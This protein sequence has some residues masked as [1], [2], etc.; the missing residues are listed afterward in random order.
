MADSH[1]G[2]HRAQLVDML[3]SRL[4][5]TCTIHTSKQLASYSRNTDS[6]YI[7]RFTDGSIANSDV[8]IGADG[9]RSAVRRSMFQDLIEQGR[10]PPGLLSPESLH[11][12]L[13]P[14]WSGI[15]VYR[16]LIQPQKLREISP[17]HLLLSSKIVMNVRSFPFIERLLNIIN[18]TW[19]SSLLERERY[20]LQVSRCMNLCDKLLYSISLPMQSP[21]EPS[22]I[23]S[24]STPILTEKGK[25]L[26][27]NG[28]MIHPRKRF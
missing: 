21:M 9:I 7:M 17:D 12:A 20:A 14:Q 23:S 26:W 11:K 13:E 19:I 18:F 15:T 27:V 2:L 16:S 24:H 1:I 4:P 5:P 3:K 28:S 25:S 22:L 6:S 10:L 8:L